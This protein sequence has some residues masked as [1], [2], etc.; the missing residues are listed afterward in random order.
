[1]YNTD[2]ITVCISVCSHTQPQQQLTQAHIYTL[3]MEASTQA[4]IHTNPEREGLQQHLP[5]AH[6]YLSVEASSNSSLRHIHIYTQTLSVEASAHSGTHRHINKMYITHIYIIIQTYTNNPERGGAPATAHS[7]T[8]KHI[9]K[10]T[11]T[12]IYKQP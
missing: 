8:H 10:F 5:Q 2:T 12:D 7:G 9:T 3:S 6:I 1:M 11:Y 4:H